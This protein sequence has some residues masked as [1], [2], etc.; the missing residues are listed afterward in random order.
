IQTSQMKPIQA[1]KKVAE[2]RHLITNEVYNIYH[3]IS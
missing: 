1:I 3:Q 2:E